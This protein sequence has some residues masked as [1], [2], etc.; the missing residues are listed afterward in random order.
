MTANQGDGRRI[1][2]GVARL[3]TPRAVTATAVG[4][5]HENRADAL[6]RVPREDP[7]GSGGFVVGVGVYC[8]ERQ[9]PVS[10]EQVLLQKYV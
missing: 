9:G 1:V 7:S 5:R 8:H 10:H 6:R 2:P 3:G 4:A